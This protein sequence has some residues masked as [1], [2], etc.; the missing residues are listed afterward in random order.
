MA[1]G[2][3]PMPPAPPHPVA[4]DGDAST[5]TAAPTTMHNTPIPI[6]T[7]T[8]ADEPNSWPTT[9]L[10]F[11]GTSSREDVPAAP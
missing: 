3:T 4:S 8:D 11:L 9:L 2:A 7:G 1:T 6:T 10:G 5:P